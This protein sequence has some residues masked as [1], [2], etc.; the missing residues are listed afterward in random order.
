MSKNKKTSNIKNKTLTTI[1][2]TRCMKM[3][4]SASLWYFRWRA[5]LTLVCD[6]LPTL[7]CLFPLLKTNLLA[8]SFCRNGNCFAW[9]EIIL[10]QNN[11]SSREIWQQGLTFGSPC[12]LPRHIYVSKLYSIRKRCCRKTK[13]DGRFRVNWQ[14]WTPK[15]Y[16]SHLGGSWRKG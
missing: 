2:L 1:T 11:G 3:F 10:K 12:L 9:Q 4:V 16:L 15:E 14:N 13:S 8:Q 7:A 6:H 5:C